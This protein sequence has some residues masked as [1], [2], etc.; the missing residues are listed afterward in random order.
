[1]PEPLRRLRLAGWAEGVTLLLLLGVAV[2]LKHLAGW[3]QGVSLMG[4]VH[5]LA[6]MTYLACAVEAVSGGG[7]TRAQAARLLGASMIPFGTFLNDR[8][9]AARQAAPEPRP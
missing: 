4:P 7:W 1:M 2:P 3:P 6:F 8:W 9:L 5:G